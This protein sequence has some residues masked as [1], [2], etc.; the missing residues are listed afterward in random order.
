MDN[1][2][3]DGVAIAGV[4]GTVVCGIGWA[5]AHLSYKLSQAGA[6]AIAKEGKKVALELAAVKAK[7]QTQVLP[8]VTLD[9]LAQPVVKEVR[10]R[11]RK[12]FAALVR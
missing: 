8:T 10:S 7:Q 4:I 6:L 1:Y 3:I 11:A 9:D 2:L 12:A 5:H